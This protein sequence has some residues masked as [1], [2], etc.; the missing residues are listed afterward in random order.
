M[1]WWH[2]SFFEQSFSCQ[3]HKVQVYITTHLH[4]IYD[5]WKFLVSWD[6]IHQSNITWHPWTQAWNIFPWL[7]SALRS[8]V[9]SPLSP[10][11]P[12]SNSTRSPHIKVKI[13][14]GV[15]RSSLI[16]KIG[17]W[18]IATHGTSPLGSSLPLK[19][20]CPLYFLYVFT[21]MDFKHISLLMPPFHCSPLERGVTS[22]PLSLQRT[23]GFCF[24]VSF[25]F[26]GGGEV[27]ELGL[28]FLK[29]PHDYS[30]Q[31]YAEYP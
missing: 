17:W 8:V 19:N 6:A 15:E 26:G 4:F 28:W 24:S 21:S 23:L 11:K 22:P 18:N 20:W 14:R 7:V 29:I 2:G 16:K 3:L 9:L 31:E 5:G 30:N 12:T 25:F 13:S 27:V 10:K 1:A